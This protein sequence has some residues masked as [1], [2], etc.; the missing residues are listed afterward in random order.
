MTRLLEY[1]GILGCFLFY[2][3]KYHTVPLQATSYKRICIDTIICRL[4]KRNGMGEVIE[5]NLKKSHASKFVVR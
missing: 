5:R 2:A 1:A 4:I 3:P